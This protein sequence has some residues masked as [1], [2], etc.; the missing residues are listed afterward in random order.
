MIQS[1]IKEHTKS[2]AN[3]NGIELTP[4]YVEFNERCQFSII[5]KDKLHAIP[6]EVLIEGYNKAE[7]NVPKHIHHSLPEEVGRVFSV[8]SVPLKPKAKQNWDARKG[9]EP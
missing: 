7:R 6:A 1:Y 9:M 4:D 8:P 2:E 3:P 5:N